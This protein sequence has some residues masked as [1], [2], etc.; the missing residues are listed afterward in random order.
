MR[1]DKVCPV[2]L[3]KKGESTEVLAFRHP[4]AGFQLVKGTVEAGEE[5]IAAAAR[6]LAEESGIEALN[7]IEFKGSWNSYYKG[8]TWHFFLCLPTETPQEEWT[9][10]TKDDGGLDFHFFWFDLEKTPGYEW[11][12]VFVSA[13]N[14]IR[15]NIA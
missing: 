2:V 13:L 15:E 10:F 8:Q 6:E 9:F 1:V 5:F 11:P 7:S 3:R 14:Y 12:D 4:L